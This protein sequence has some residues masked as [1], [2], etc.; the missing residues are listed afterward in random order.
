MARKLVSRH[1]KLAI[2]C[3]MAAFPLLMINKAYA[4][5]SLNNFVVI[6]D[7]TPSVATTHHYGFTYNDINS[8]GSV[9]FEYC[10]NTA[11][12][13]DPCSPPAGFDASGAVLTGQTGET[14][15]SINTSV[16]TTN[17]IVL[18]R[19]ASVNAAIPVTYDFSNI[20]NPSAPRETVF[21]RLSS[22]AS[23][24]ATGPYTVHGAAAFATLTN[25][26]VV[27]FVPPYLTFCVGV[28]VALNCSNSTGTLLDFGELLPTQVK[29]VSS[30]FAVA[31]NDVTG[32]SLSMAGITMT[33]GN[34]IIPGIPAPQPSQPGTG[35]FGLNLRNNS[36]PDVGAEP[37]GVGTGAVAPGYNVPNQFNFVNGVIASSTLPTDFNA[38]TVSYICNVNQS[39]KPGIYAT[40]ITY[41]ASVSF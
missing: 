28:V 7:S 9:L 14:G 6:G 34:N 35:Q 13:S 29:Y 23:D 36:N 21:V 17:R 39:Q 3:L 11:F 4:L 19:T 18:S 12:V 33:S 32:Y 20:V 37:I 41:I 16:S 27:G 1:L 5:P 15:Y 25:P 22:Y 24:D 30:Q 40:T 8:V 31:T 26:I 38:F 2:A 10:T